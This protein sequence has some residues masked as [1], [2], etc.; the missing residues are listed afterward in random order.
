MAILDHRRG[1]ALL[2]AF[3]LAGYLFTC[4]LGL[5]GYVLCTE[6]DSHGVIEASANLHGCGCP[7]A[8]A[9][10]ARLLGTDDCGPCVDHSLSGE[11]FARF[12]PGMDPSPPALLPHAHR[13]PSPSAWSS[14]LGPA[15]RTRHP[16]ARAL[17]LLRSTVL[18][19]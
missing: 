10:S 4:S 8:S 12:G 3:G 15:F 6:A 7:A 13:L 16:G 14:H 18:L 9:S 5:S 17:D 11:G 1:R 2:T 19:I